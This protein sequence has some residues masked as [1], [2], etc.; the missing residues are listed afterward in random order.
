[1]IQ[2]RSS[3]RMYRLS[4]IAQRFTGEFLKGYRVVSHRF[5][6]TAKKYLIRA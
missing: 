2:G 4:R 1:M 6:A 3:F 5:E